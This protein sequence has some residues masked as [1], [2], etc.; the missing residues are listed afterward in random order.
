MSFSMQ[1]NNPYSQGCFVSLA[2][3]F[4]NHK[5]ISDAIESPSRNFM[6]RTP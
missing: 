3:F 5:Q 6:T 2:Y 4:K 1:Q